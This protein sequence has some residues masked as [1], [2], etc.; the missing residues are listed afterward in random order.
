MDHHYDVLIVG[1]GHGG[2]MAASTLRQ[3]GFNGTVAIVSYEDSIPYQ[4]PPLS[5]GY[6]AGTIDLGQM[7]I[8][9]ESFWADQRIAL[10]LGRRVDV[11]D[12]ESKRVVTH[13]GEEISYG[14][15]VWAAGSRPRLLDCPGQELSGVHVIRTLS[16]AD[17][18]KSDVARASKVVLVGAGYVGLETA[19]V[20]RKLN[21]QVTILETM[22]RV[23]ARVSAAPMSRFFEDE[24]R[25][26]GADVRLESEVVGFEGSGGHLRAAH[27]SSGEVLPCEVVVVGAGSIPSG[28]P[29][30]QAGAASDRGV[31]V[32]GYCRTSLPDVF[33]IGDCAVAPNE[34]ADGRA[35]RLESVQN[36]VDQG[37]G[38]ARLLA[39]AEHLSPAVPTFWSD[40]YDIRLRTVGLSQGHDTTV[41][42]GD[43]ESR[44]FSV[45]YMRSGAVVAIDSVN[46][47]KDFAQGKALVRSRAEIE[48]GR[49]ADPSLPFSELGH[50]AAVKR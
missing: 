41:V 19:A 16:D 45:I 44:S 10:V 50:R 34:Y 18:L 2:S 7:L 31:L 38:V 22:D 24:H 9:P 1:S 8:L 12:V 37:I 40:Q 20:L 4:R 29:L 15:L 11:V 23:L 25:A 33:A 39:G 30:I 46:A 21:K 42:R 6:L 13:E 14:T 43:P 27:L 26:Q 28:E 48:V 17:R 35:V 36:A 49:L 3:H 47:M 5:K 32:D